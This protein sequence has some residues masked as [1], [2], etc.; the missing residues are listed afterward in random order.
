MRYANESN[1]PR[2]LNFGVA[3]EEELRRSAPD[4]AQFPSMQDLMR[5]E[6]LTD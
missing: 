3:V 2:A 4:L 1:N 6:G 5:C